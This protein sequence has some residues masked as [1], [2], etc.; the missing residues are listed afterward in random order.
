MTE[1]KEAA[2]N[3]E[4][5]PGE[6]PRYGEGGGEAA[7]MEKAAERSKGAGTTEAP[8]RSAVKT[9]AGEP[10]PERAPRESHGPADHR[11]TQV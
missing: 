1:Q 9:E 2:V 3:N 7:S 11:P 4:T 6:V 10:T 8:G 5:Q